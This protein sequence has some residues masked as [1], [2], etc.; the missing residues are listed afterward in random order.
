M[1]EKKNDLSSL[2]GKVEVNDMIS[3]LQETSARRGRSAKST[4]LPF[5]CF[6]HF[7]LQD[8]ILIYNAIA[9]N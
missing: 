6:L 2:N 8:V 4:A 9:C 1:K 5:H 7:R 3:S